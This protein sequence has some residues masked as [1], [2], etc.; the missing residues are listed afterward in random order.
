MT[1][2][3]LGV[4]VRDPGDRRFVWCRDSKVPLLAESTTKRKL[5]SIC[6]K[7]VGH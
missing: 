2:G 5:L 4:R 7:L 6:G 1:L 3:V